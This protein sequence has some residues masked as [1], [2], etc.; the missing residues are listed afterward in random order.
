VP[1]LPVAHIDLVSPGGTALRPGSSVGFRQGWI[2]RGGKFS[3]VFLAPMLRLAHPAFQ[4]SAG[5]TPFDVAGL[6]GFSGVAT[7][8][9]HYNEHPS[10]DPD[11]RRRTADRFAVDQFWRDRLETE[12]GSYLRDTRLRRANLLDL[13]GCLPVNQ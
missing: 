4:I 8:S 3:V 1:V 11:V 9:D 6:R 10:H 7:A 5:D 2:S 12:G 13:S